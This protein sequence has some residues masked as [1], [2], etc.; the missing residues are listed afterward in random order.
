MTSS[1][2]EDFY[3][4]KARKEAFVSNL[5]GTTRLEIVII[6]ILFPAF[7]LYRTLARC[8]FF[9]RK[10][11]YHA[12]LKEFALLIVIPLFCITVLLSILYILWVFASH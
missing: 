7:Y 8:G 6:G 11:L 1:N 5:K 12:F 2:N 4:Y 3:S 9:P 10:N